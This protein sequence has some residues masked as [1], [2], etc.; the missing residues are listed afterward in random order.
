MFSP[1]ST[2]TKKS[3]PKQKTRNKNKSYTEKLY[4]KNAAPEDYQTGMRDNEKN[5]LPLPLPYDVNLYSSPYNT[6]FTPTHGERN[7]PP[8]AEVQFNNPLCSARK[9]WPPFYSESYLNENKMPFNPAPESLQV[10]NYLD[11][12][13]YDE[14]ALPFTSENPVSTLPQQ[15]GISSPCITMTPTPQGQKQADHEK[16]YVAALREQIFALKMTVIQKDNIIARLEQKIIH[17]EKMKKNDD[18]LIKLKD[19]IISN[20]AKMI[21]QPPA[22][23]LFN[24]RKNTNVPLSPSINNLL[25]QGEPSQANNAMLFNKFHAYEYSKI[26]KNQRDFSPTSQ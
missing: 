13:T 23:P 5:S 10:E 12:S 26:L 18:K 4:A 11:F 16:A 25:N 3:K 21:P 8:S 19:E 2:I 22:Q 24:Q 15:T 1:K 7:D 6:F 20:N 9:L 17:Y 14:P